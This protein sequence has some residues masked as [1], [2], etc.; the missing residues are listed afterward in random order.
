VLAAVSEFSALDTSALKKFLQQWKSREHGIIDR[1]AAF[2]WFLDRLC[3]AGSG[4]REIVLCKDVFRTVRIYA[5]LPL[6]GKEGC[7]WIAT[8]EYHT[9]Y[10]VMTKRLVLVWIVANFLAYQCSTINFSS[11]F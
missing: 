11:F 7:V 9:N 5:W 1:T 8:K 2:A 6:F 4:Y 3:R 10:L